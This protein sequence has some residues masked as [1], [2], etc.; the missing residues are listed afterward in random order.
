MHS[1]DL[2]AS[3]GLPLPEFPDVVVEHVVHL[4]TGVALRRHGQAA[5]IRGAQPTAACTEL[6]L[7]VLTAHL[8]AAATAAIS[9]ES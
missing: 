7:R 1:D 3:V 4:L 6:D 2:A 5:V 9:S 8:K